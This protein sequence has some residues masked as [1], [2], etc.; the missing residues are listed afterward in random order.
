[1]GNARHVSSGMFQAKDLVI[2]IH[3]ERGRPM[4]SVIFLIQVGDNVATALE[5]LF[6]APPAN[7]NSGKFFLLRTFP[8]RNLAM[9]CPTH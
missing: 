9:P 5:S 8:K 4:P 1:M 7:P 2:A 6:G 3:L